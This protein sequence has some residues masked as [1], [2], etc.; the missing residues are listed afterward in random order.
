MSKHD[1][2][3]LFERYMDVLTT[4]M[5]QEETDNTNNTDNTDN[6]NNTN[7]DELRTYLSEYCTNPNMVNT[8]GNTILHLFLKV[9]KVVKTYQTFKL[10]INTGVNIDLINKKKEN[11]IDI[12][13]DN[14]SKESDNEQKNIY[15]MML[16][17][18]VLIKSEKGTLCV[19]TLLLLLNMRYYLTLRKI[20]KTKSIMEKLS[21]C[22]ILML[23]ISAIKKYCSL[24]Q[25]EITMQTDATNAINMDALRTSIYKIVKYHD[26]SQSFTD[27][28]V[29]YETIYEYIYKK[30]RCMLYSKTNIYD[31]TTISPSYE[32][33]MVY[34]VGNIMHS[35]NTIVKIMDDDMFKYFLSLGIHKHSVRCSYFDFAQDCILKYLGSSVCLEILLLPQKQNTKSIMMMAVHDR[36]MDFLSKCLRYIIDNINE[37]K[38]ECNILNVVDKVKNNIMHYIFAYCKNNN[39]PIYKQFYRMIIET[40]YK[41]LMHSM[42]FHNCTPYNIACICNYFEF[43]KYIMDTNDI[44]KIYDDMKTIPKAQP[45]TQSLILSS[46]DGYFYYSTS[47]T[48]TNNITRITKTTTYHVLSLVDCF[49]KNYSEKDLCDNFVRVVENENLV[50]DNPNHMVIKPYIYSCMNSKKKYSS[51]NECIGDNNVIKIL[52][53]IYAVNPSYINDV[54]EFGRTCYVLSVE[55]NSYRYVEFYV[56]LYKET[57]SA[58]DFYAKL[59]QD[60]EINGNNVFHHIAYNG[61]EQ[62]FKLI[63]DNIADKQLLKNSFAKRNIIGVSPLKISIEEKNFNI[64]KL[65]LECEGTIDIVPNLIWYLCFNPNFKDDIDNVKYLESKTKY[66]LLNTHLCVP[67]RNLPTVHTPICNLI[68]FCGYNKYSKLLKYLI[69]SCIEKKKENMLHDIDANG[70]SLLSIGIMTNNMAIIDMFAFYN[71]KA[72]RE[73]HFKIF[74]MIGDMTKTNIFLK[75]IKYDMFDVNYK[76]EEMSIMHRVCMKG[77][78]TLVQ[79]IINKNNDNNVKT[80]L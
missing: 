67:N 61:N 31:I 11:A 65:M 38:H 48:Y 32:S 18:L 29:K 4:H 12:I 62:M 28:G 57:Y 23:L 2:K 3:I 45:L 70:N 16:Y 13:I 54:D 20:V 46:W 7:A 63:C 47:Y 74:N 26:V 80:E 49:M 77:D 15:T 39:D 17:D 5:L 66:D 68:H 50:Y 40:K 35:S 27:D 60:S 43:V 24:C 71:I 30:M 72:S 37:I 53:E 79:A 75:M 34:F 44:V 22:Q 1:K 8:Q 9:N 58:G 64:M 52:K 69:M 14:N 78:I 6:T 76:F 73:D 55:I 59:L 33:T 19:R 25:M 42:N 36:S 10:I 41:V 56:N 51:K 21:S